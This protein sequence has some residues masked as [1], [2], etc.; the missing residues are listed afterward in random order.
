MSDEQKETQYLFKSESVNEEPIEDVTSSLLPKRNIGLLQ[1]VCSFHFFSF[2]F[3][4]FF[5]YVF[6]FSFSLPLLFFCPDHQKR[7]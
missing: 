3:F 5:F 4:F 1:L 7:L 6:F 2:F